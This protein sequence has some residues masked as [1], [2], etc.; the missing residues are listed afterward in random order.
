M[1]RKATITVKYAL[2]DAE[3]PSAHLYWAIRNGDL[4]TVKIAG[5]RLIFRDSFD[6]WKKRLN[7]RRE[8]L[9]EA[10]EV[11]ELQAV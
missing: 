3:V 10:Q 4:R 11:R 5:R 6:N 2:R 9:K 8:L 1:K 7:Q